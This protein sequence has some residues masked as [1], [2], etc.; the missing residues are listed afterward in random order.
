MVNA[1][2]PVLMPWADRVDAVL[3]AGLPGQEGGAAVA[4]V[5]L[6]LQEPSGRLVTTWPTADGA[7][8]AWSVTPVDGALPYREGTFVGYRG[9]AAGHAPAPHFWFGHGLGYGTWDYLGARTDGLAVTVTLRNTSARP[10]REVVQVYLSPAEPDQPV[11]LAGWASEEVPAGDTVEVTVRCDARMWRRWDAAAGGW[12]PLEG[13]ELL[14]ARGLGD[15]RLR[16]P[17]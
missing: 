7:T 11:R 15:V 4:D 5:L 17:L 16:L 12:A 8:P 6:G 14:V 13:G 9:H 10:S 2:T 3:V 1:A